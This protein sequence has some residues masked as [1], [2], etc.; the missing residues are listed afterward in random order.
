MINDFIK[1]VLKIKTYKTKLYNS[2]KDNITYEII[3]NEFQNL[4]LQS[5]RGVKQQFDRFSITIEIS[6]ITN[7]LLP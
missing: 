2:W 4:V 1:N 6:L 7:E 3:L 5:T